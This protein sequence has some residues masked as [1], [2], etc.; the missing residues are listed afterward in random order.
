MEHF[1][2]KNYESAMYLFSKISKEDAQNYKE[3]IKEIEESKP[4]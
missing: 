3:A 2:N 1:K 4:L